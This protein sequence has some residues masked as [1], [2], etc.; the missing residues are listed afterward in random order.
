MTKSTAQITDISN[1]DS[2]VRKAPSFSHVQPINLR[3]LYSVLASNGAAVGRALG[4]AGSTITEHLNLNQTTEIYELA[5]KQL[6][7]QM[8]AQ[9]KTDAEAV[10][11]HLEAIAVYFENTP[12]LDVPSELFVLLGSSFAHVLREAAGK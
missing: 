12:A 1:T 11:T 10:L 4:V 5:S 8:D 3:R 6:L 9:P 2:L 7:S